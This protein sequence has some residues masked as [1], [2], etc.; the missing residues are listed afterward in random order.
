[1]QRRTLLATVAMGIATVATGCL[2][3]LETTTADATDH[4][5]DVPLHITVTNDT[6]HTHQA[7]IEFTHVMTPT[8]RYDTPACGQPTRSHT[9]IDATVTL[10]PGE[11]ATYEPAL[12]RLEPGDDHVDTYAFTVATD[13][14][15]TTLQGLE[16]GGAATIGDQD[17]QNYPWRVADHGYALTATI[18]DDDI[19]IMVAPLA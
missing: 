16:A 4:L 15:S 12:T 13:H 3:V 19:D 8:C 2:S 17:A 1:M 5:D 10:A 11:A 9:N 7:T 18:T 6:D 14:E